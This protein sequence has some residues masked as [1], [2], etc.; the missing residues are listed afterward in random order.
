MISIIHLETIKNIFFLYTQPIKS[1]LIKLLSFLTVYFFTVIIILHYCWLL[2]SLSSQIYSIHF[3]LCLADDEAG[4][5][6]ALHRRRNLLAAFC[7]LIVYNVIEIK[8]GADIFKQYMR[9]SLIYVVTFL[10]VC[11]LMLTP[12]LCLCVV[13]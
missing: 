2:F 7:K 13:L 12:C 10:C 11:Y 4:K 3:C 9:V 6:E 8:T 5:I 1:L